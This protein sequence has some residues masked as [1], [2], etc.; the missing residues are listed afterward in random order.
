MALVY[1]SHVFDHPDRTYCERCNDDFAMHEFVWDDS[2][3]SLT[4]YYSRYAGMFKGRDRFFGSETMVFSSIAVGALVGGVAGFLIGRAWG[5]LATIGAAVLGV[6]LV[7][8]VGFV[9]GAAIKQRV[10]R[11]VLGTDDFTLLD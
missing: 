7:G 4:D 2:G 6:V 3:E 5:I 9:V 8:F 1:V 10:C 11:R